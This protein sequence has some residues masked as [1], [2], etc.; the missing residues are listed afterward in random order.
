[1]T[2]VGLGEQAGL[3]L[4]VLWSMALGGVIGWERQLVA[5]PA[6]LRTHMLVAGAATLFTGVT[7][8][9]ALLSA[10]GDPSRGAH[11]LITGIGFLG[12]GA[13]LQQRDLGP[14]GLTTAA[15]II[16]TAVVGTAVAAGFGLAASVATLMAIA[17]LRILGRG[18]RDG[19]DRAS[20]ATGAG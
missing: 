9:M 8:S 5:K 18:R 19:P 11:G 7:S 14:S 15:T 1:M 4:L 6:G 3:L 20:D 2:E 17:V 13:I 12:A 10:T 16:Y